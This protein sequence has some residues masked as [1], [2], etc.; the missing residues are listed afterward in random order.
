[1]SGVLSITTAFSR[2]DSDRCRLTTTSSMWS[3]VSA[4]VCG[5]V[6]ASSPTTIGEDDVDVVMEEGS[7][8]KTMTMALLQLSLFEFVAS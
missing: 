1:M 4:A 2:S 7:I 8:L 6:G 5:E 3:M